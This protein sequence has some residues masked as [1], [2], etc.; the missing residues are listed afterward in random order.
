MGWL[1]AG[2]AGSGSSFATMS[3][4][5]VVSIV[6]G[7]TAFDEG[8]EMV[9]EPDLTLT[10]YTAEPGSPSEE[11]L[12]LLASWAASQDSEQR[13]EQSAQGP[14]AARSTWAGGLGQVA[15]SRSSR[16]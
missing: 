9:A 8:L 2:S 12:R 14:Q 3:A 11:R 7:Q 13:H 6:P 15:F 16:G 4:T 1:R 10:T 5:M